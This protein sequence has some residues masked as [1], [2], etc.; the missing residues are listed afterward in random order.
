MATEERKGSYR[1]R[2]L[3]LGAIAVV[4]LAAA[5]LRVYESA[6]LE[7]ARRAEGARAQAERER[8]LL[9]RGD[10]T[11][12]A[13]ERVRRAPNVVFVEPRPG[14]APVLAFAPLDPARRAGP[15][16]GRVL[17]AIEAERVYAAGG[18]LVC[19]GAHA[20]DD[21]A[22]QPGAF[23]LDDDLRIVRRFRLEGLPSRVRVSADGSRAAA[24]FFVTGDS[25]AGRGFSTRTYVLDL[26]GAEPPLD[27]ERFTVEH[28]GRVVDAADR[29]YWGVTF[30]APPSRFLATLRT[31]DERL[32]VELDGAAR[33]GR[34]LHAQVE[35]P[36]LSPKQ[37][38]IAFKRLVQEPFERWAIATL[39]LATKTERVLPGEE[40]SI[41]DQVEWLDDDH[42]LYA[43]GKPDE[44]GGATADVW[45][46][47]VV[48]AGAPR[49]FLERARSPCVVR[50]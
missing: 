15:D 30:F 18:A 45:S 11:L 7:R 32:L 44:W 31:G 16:G 22:S 27:L 39:D 29:N 36:S 26:A 42:V 3:A 33:T 38:R 48:G 12:L 28:A 2:I 49:V 4:L 10:S 24:T 6:K 23:V 17:T 40:R 9:E 1:V 25:Y 19:L 46:A 5:G 34:T 50:P 41:D 21:G 37:D 8:E 47:P 14:L 20:G 43:I 13:V 35:C